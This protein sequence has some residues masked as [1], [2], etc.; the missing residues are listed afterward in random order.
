MRCVVYS[1]VGGPEVVS[2]E[3]RPD[4]TPGKFEVLIATAF[5][6]VNPA[7]VLQREGRHPVPPGAPKDVPGLEVA[8]TVVASG[9]AVTAFNVGDRV[10]GLVGGGGLAERVVANERDLMPLPPS[11]DDMAAAAA[12][13]AFLTAFDAICLQ[14][15][16]GSGDTL[17]VNGGNGGVGT[18]AIQIASRFGA[19]VVASIRS[20]ELRPR[21][22]ELG[23]TALEAGGAFEHV[24]SVGGADVILELVGAPNMTENLGS[25]AK[26]GRIVIVG[27]KPGDEATI[28]MRDLMT[29]RGRIMG[30]TLRTRPPEQKASLAQEFR[31]RVLPLLASGAAVPIVD[32]VFGFD[33]ICEA[34]DHVRAPGKFGRVLL[35]TAE[36]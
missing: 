19:R 9:D 3:E 17:L 27:S 8:G 23:A 15:G 34:L 18:A 16:L 20:E 6:G 36:A 35:R 21:V 13:E 12:P 11:L 2:V 4:P 14:A 24:R 30:T 10:F 7:D 26:L 32:R 31:R 1:G 22:A 25:L 28:D 5:S 33:E 29:R